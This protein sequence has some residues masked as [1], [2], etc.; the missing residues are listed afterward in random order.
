MLLS[1]WGAVILCG[2]SG[3]HGNHGVG[4]SQWSFGDHPTGLLPCKEREPVS[5]PRMA[6]LQAHP[7]GAQ[8]MRERV[9][10]SRTSL[11]VDVCFFPSFVLPKLKQK[12]MVFFFFWLCWVCI[13]CVWVVSSCSGK[14]LLSSCGVQ[15][16]ITQA[17]LV[18]KRRLHNTGSVVLVNG[19]SLP[20]RGDRTRVP[21]IG[22][23]ILH[24]RTTREVQSPRLLLRPK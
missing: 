16:S 12:K 15:A 9:F 1:H 10:F 17:S 6:N 22:R 14:G 19:L 3:H 7:T 20:E 2:T 23:G 8:S 11:C 13:C 4:L 21:R 5:P 18:A 24:H